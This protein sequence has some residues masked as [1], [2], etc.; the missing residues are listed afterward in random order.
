MTEPPADDHPARP[1]TRAESAAY[2]RELRAW[3][4]ETHN[5]S[6]VKPVPRRPPSTLKPTKN[7]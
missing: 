6:Q 4:R 1:M 3:Y 2:V 5:P 7:R